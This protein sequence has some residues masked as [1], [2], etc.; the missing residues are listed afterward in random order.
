MNF[1][2][3]SIYK[4]CEHFVSLLILPVLCYCSQLIL[5]SCRRL[6]LIIKWLNHGQQLKTIIIL[7]SNWYEPAKSFWLFLKLNPWHYWETSSACYIATRTLK[8]T[9]RQDINSQPNGN[10]SL[11]TVIPIGIVST[12]CPRLGFWRAVIPLHSEPT[13]VF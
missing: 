4:S 11:K 6:A 8:I 13:T 7:S 2:F 9:W 3:L 12:W 5:K 10:H 1:Y